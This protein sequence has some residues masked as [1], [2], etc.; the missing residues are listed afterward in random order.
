[1]PSTLPMCPPEAV[2]IG[3]SCFAVLISDDTFTYF[4]NL[5]PF[6]SHAADDRTAML[7][8]I[9]RLA[10]ISAVSPQE[11][12]DAFAVSRATVQRARRR[13]LAEGEAGFMKP[14]R[15][16]GP[17]VFTPELAEKATALLASGLS[18]SAAARVLGVSAPSVNKWRRQGLI[19]NTEA[20][21]EPGRSALAAPPDAGAAPEGRVDEESTGAPGPETAPGLEAQ[22][23][24]DRSARDRR[25]RQAPMGRATCDVPARVLA[26]CGQAGPVE[27]QFAAAARGV[28]FGGVLA[29]LPALLKE[30]LLSETGL[31]PL[32]PKGNCP[33]TPSLL[34]NKPVPFASTPPRRGGAYS[35]GNCPGTP[36]LL[37]NKPVPFASTPP[38]RGGA[39]SL[40]RERMMNAASRTR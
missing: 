37:W 30:G 25:D 17:S 29:A 26:S 31:L 4:S 32:L 36:S 13:Y 18:G 38:R 6:D 16:R 2:S 5:I 23:Q 22:P 33:G 28:R 10:A 12:A 24:T 34:W 14:R 3:N 1:M 27:P 9:G 21:G 40:E 19:G 15:G 7:L 35:L 39:Y 8:R 11:L 20:D